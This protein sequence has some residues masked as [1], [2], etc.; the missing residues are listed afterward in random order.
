MTLLKKIIRFSALFCISIGILFSPFTHAKELYITD[1][2][3]NSLSDE[4][5][6]PEYVAKAKKELRATEMREQSQNQLS[7]E[8]RDALG[9]MYNFET[10]IRTQYPS[11]H[12][13]YSKL[14]T[15]DRVL[16]FD[17]FKKSKKLST[18]KRM[19]IKKYEK[20][21]NK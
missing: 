17:E 19:I 7:A 9:S 14:N 5:S 4:A 8:I 2:Y 21:Y 1:D 3:L 20:L 13:I 16:I 18:A 6:S 15:S 11:S 12:A 10:L